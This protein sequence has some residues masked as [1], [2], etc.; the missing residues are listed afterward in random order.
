M[1]NINFGLSA[2]SDVRHTGLKLPRHLVRELRFIV[3]DR[4]SPGVCSDVQRAI[5]RILPASMKCRCWCADHQPGVPPRRRVVLNPEDRAQLQRVAR[6]SGSKKQSAKAR[7]TGDAIA[8]RVH[9]S[10]TCDRED[11]ARSV[12]P[13]SIL[14]AATEIQLPP[15]ELRIRRVPKALAGGPIPEDQ[16]GIRFL[17]PGIVGDDGESHRA[18]LARVHRI[19]DQIRNLVQSSTRVRQR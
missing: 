13:S 5:G 1:L 2:L 7:A 9:E 18:I 16:L 11:R 15:S 6:F 3:E 8:Y 19:P 14:A 4:E 17:V 10:Q 12:P